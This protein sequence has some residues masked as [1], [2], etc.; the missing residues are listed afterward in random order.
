MRSLKELEKRIG[1]KFKDEKL[2]EM[3]LTHSSYMSELS[4]EVQNNERLEFLGDAVLGMLTNEYLYKI[5]VTADEGMLSKRKAVLVSET[6]LAKRANC[7]GLG[8]FL[9]MSKGEEQSGGRERPSLLADAFE[10]IIGAMYLDGGLRRT[11]TF[12]VRELSEELLLIEKGEEGK[13]Y[14]SILQE[15]LQAK[16]KTGPIY[17]V[18]EERGPD[19]DKVFVVEVQGGKKVL[20]RGVGKSK[21]EAEQ[22]AAE[23]G[24]LSLKRF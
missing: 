21:K 2:L 11:R 6:I 1:F 18:V 19:H 17:H 3:A 5:Y 20:G 23:T 12:V 15:V 8:S 10:A 4:D 9:Y 16:I 24:L 14:K 22:A 7:L 13:D